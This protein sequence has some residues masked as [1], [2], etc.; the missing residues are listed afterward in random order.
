MTGS[1]ILSVAYGFDVNVVQDSIHTYNAE[2]AMDGF[3]AASIPGSFLV[4][5]YLPSQ[6][7]V[8]YLIWIL[9]GSPSVAKIYSIMGPWSLVPMPSSDLA[10]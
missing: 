3:I 5:S 6:L 8:F 7:L 1:S 4:V 10:G 9:A 2:K